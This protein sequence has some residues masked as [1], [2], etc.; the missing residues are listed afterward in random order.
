MVA[1]GVWHSVPIWQCE[2]SDLQ[3]GL[4][5]FASRRKYLRDLHQRRILCH[6]CHLQSSTAASTLTNMGATPTTPNGQWQAGPFDTA[7][8]GVGT[9]LN[10]NCNPGYTEQ[11]AGASLQ[12]GSAL[13]ADKWTG[14][15]LTA[16]CVVGTGSNTGANNNNKCLAPV[17]VQNGVWTEPPFSDFVTGTTATLTCNAGYVSNPPSASLTCG[18]DGLWIFPGAYPTCS[19]SGSSPPPPSGSFCTAPPVN[20]GTWSSPPG[21]AGFSQGETTTLQCNP[22]YVAVPAGASMTCNNVFGSLSFSGTGLSAKCVEQANSG[23]SNGVGECLAPVAVQHGQWS[24]PPFVGYEVGATT[25]LICDPG[26]S[27]FPDSSATM[28]CDNQLLWL[29]TGDYATCVQGQ[30]T[31]MPC[32]YDDL[33]Y[34]VNGAWSPP[35]SGSTY[36][37]GSASTLTC[38]AGYTI[39]PPGA[40]SFITCTNGVFSTTTT[41]CVQGTSNPN[42]GAGCAGGA[43]CTTDCTTSQL[44]PVSGGVWSQPVFGTAFPS[45]SASSLTCNAGFQVSPPGASTFVTCTNGAF[46]ATTATCSPAPPPAP[47]QTWEPLLPRRM[48][49]GKR[50]PLILP[51]MAWVPY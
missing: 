1:A 37:S 13:G 36:T 29:F 40:S 16:T 11:P 38:D 44:P 26:Y 22:G 19:S 48:V 21:A 10:L 50:V 41:T 32:T 49:N 45:G 14:A 47:S 5:G 30:T 24:Q 34:A 20:Y 6:D 15:G 2:L 17:T 39:S 3:R 7:P 12:C 8:Y 46:S 31:T 43:S 51:R 4:S 27:A 33:P 42:S 23:G 9:V 25:T 18:S 28:T 35:T